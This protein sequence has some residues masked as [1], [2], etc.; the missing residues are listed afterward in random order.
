MSV[1]EESLFPD[2]AGGE[3]SLVST[4]TDH[5]GVDLQTTFHH[6]EVCGDGRPAVGEID[7]EGAGAI[8]IHRVSTRG[9]GVGEIGDDLAINRNRVDLGE[10]TLAIEL[11]HRY[12]HL[13]AGGSLASQFVALDGE[14]VVA[15][16]EAVVAGSKRFTL[17][18]S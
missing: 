18:V 9:R 12:P 1:F 17:R 13:R 10:P 16:D 8:G 5:Y 4:R 15:G 2:A 6:D 7:C 11:S 14:S 3:Y